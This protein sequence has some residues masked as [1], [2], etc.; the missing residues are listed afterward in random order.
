MQNSF[1]EADDSYIFEE[2]DIRMS[3]AAMF[4]PYQDLSLEKGLTGW[5]RYFIYRL[6]GNVYKNNKLQKAL[7]HIACEVEQKTAKNDVSENEQLDVYRFLCDLT[8]LPG[9]AV[10]YRNFAA[11]QK[12]E[13]YMRA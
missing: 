9:Y 7:T 4:E 12:M 2:F 6:R 5:G 10:K 3:R 13:M 8:S 11:V 1:L